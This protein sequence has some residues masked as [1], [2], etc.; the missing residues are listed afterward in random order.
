M[1]RKSILP[2]ILAVFAPSTVAQLSLFRNA[3]APYDTTRIIAQRTWEDAS[4][5]AYAFV[6]QLN[7]TEKAALMTG[8]ISGAC[9]GNMNPIPRLNFSG[10]CLHDGPA[11]IRAADL[12]SLFPA[13]VTTGA[14]WDK[15]L[16]YARGLA[17]GEEFRGKGAHMALAP[18][19]GLLGRH[20]LGGRKW[21]GFGADLYLAGAAM[22]AT[23]R[24][25]QDAGVQACAKHYIGNEP[26]TQRFNVITDGINTEAISSYIDHRTLHK[27][28][29]WPSANS[30][31]A[32]TSS[33]MCSYNRLNLTYT[34]ERTNLST[35][36]SR[37]S[38]ISKDMILTAYFCLKQDQD[39][40]IVNPM[41]IYLTYGQAIDTIATPSAR[42]VKDDHISLTREVAA[43]GTVLL[44]NQRSLLPIQNITNVA[45]FENAAPNTADGLYFAGYTGTSNDCPHGAKY[46]ALPVGGGSGHR[47]KGRLTTIFPIPDICLVFLKTF[48]TE[49]WDRLSFENDWNST[50]VVRNIAKSIYCSNKA[51][52]ITQSAGVNTLPWADN[53]T[54]ILAPHYSG[55][56]AGNSVVEFF[57]AMLIHRFGYGLGYTTF[58]LS[59]SITID[60]VGEDIAALPPAVSGT[61]PGG[62]PDLWNVV[63]NV[64]A[65]VI[66]TGAAAGAAVPHLYV[67]FPLGDVGSAPVGTP[68]KVLCGFEKVKLKPS[69]STNVTLPLMR[70]DV[71][72][73]SVSEQ[74]WKI[75]EGNIDISIGFS[76]WDIKATASTELLQ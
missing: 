48:A 64:T 45:V 60:K 15:D 23:I 42:Y 32:G 26:E 24:G 76:P 74:E 69:Q 25:F 17:M 37:M 57:G 18:V 22:D 49:G 21:E 51:V 54:I 41:N 56:Q 55:D 35:R 50:L 19:A 30:V 13:G 70:R 27:L 71:S 65:K 8:N 2:A 52:V 75:S 44:M 47:P 16:M 63:L 11:A 38:W 29:L 53:V 61:L 28:H 67:S 36:S 33:I 62:N 31:N 7:L 43:A 3:V 14:T 34:C 12:A 1:L 39:F 4:A 68:L 66:N 73:W 10:L 6:S 9:D 58:N 5:L 59:S 72:F 20:P 40:P 46:R